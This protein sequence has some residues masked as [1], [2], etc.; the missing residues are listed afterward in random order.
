MDYPAKVKAAGKN[1]YSAEPVLPDPSA[2]AADDGI[3]VEVEIGGEKYSGKL[4]K[5]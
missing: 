3:S 1:G 4:N 2:P 5:A